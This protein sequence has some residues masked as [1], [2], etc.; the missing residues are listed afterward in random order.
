MRLIPR[1][2]PQRRIGLTSDQDTDE[3]SEMVSQSDPMGVV[4]PAAWRCRDPP[5]VSPIS[6][7]P[8]RQKSSPETVKQY[9]D[10]LHSNTAILRIIEEFIGDIRWKLAAIDGIRLTAVHPDGFTVI[11]DGIEEH[12]P[13][14]IDLK[15]LRNCENHGDAFQYPINATIFPD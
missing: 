9:F 12:F 2:D 3:L 7:P 5:P 6:A 13:N 1:F 11:R 4:R 14:D 8:E 10:M 15:A